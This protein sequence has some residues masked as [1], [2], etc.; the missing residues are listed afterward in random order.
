MFE[1]D[2]N[3]RDQR[4]DLIV[5]IDGEIIDTEEEFID[6]LEEITHKEEEDTEDG[7]Q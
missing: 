6:S 3:E 4:E 5:G 2:F 1:E 7:K